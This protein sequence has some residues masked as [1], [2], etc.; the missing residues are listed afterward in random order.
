MIFLC[1]EP[2][3]VDTLVSCMIGDSDSRGAST[4]AAMQP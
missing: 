3:K 1:N 2:L 4:D